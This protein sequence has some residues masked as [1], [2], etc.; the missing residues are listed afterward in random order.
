MVCT[1]WPRTGIVSALFVQTLTSGSG[2]TGVSHDVNRCRIWDKDTPGTTYAAGNGTGE[3]IVDF[4]R[5]KLDVKCGV[6]KRI[7]RTPYVR[8]NRINK[9][10]G[11]NTRVTR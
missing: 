2:T 5:V 6:L 10:C 1:A 7:K 4:G 11:P 9:L 3:V 8:L